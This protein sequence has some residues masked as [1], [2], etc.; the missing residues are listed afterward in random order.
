MSV[1]LVNVITIVAL[2]AVLML[3]VNKFVPMDSKLKKALNIGV[4]IGVVLW[5]LFAVGVLGPATQMETPQAPETNVTGE[6]QPDIGV[7]PPPP[8]PAA[9]PVPE[10]APSDEVPPAATPSAPDTGATAPAP[11]PDVA[12]PPPEPPQAKE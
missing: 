8:E 4:V 5:L 2:V 10:A 6:T 11:Q 1:S 3:L 9:Q 12:A 7:P